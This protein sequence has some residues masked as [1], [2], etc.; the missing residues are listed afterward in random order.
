MAQAQ[1]IGGARDGATEL[2]KRQLD[3]SVH[4]GTGQR[5]EPTAASLGGIKSEAGSSPQ[6]QAPP[7]NPRL[8]PTASGALPTWPISLMRT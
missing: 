3:G 6:P 1:S 8:L 7:R 2:W 5:V 4:L